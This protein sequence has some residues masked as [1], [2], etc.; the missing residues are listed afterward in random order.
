[1]IR[2]QADVE[3]HLL[4]DC[5]GLR[6]GVVGLG[7]TIWIW[8]AKAAVAVGLWM[9]CLEYVV[10]LLRALA[11]LTGRLSIETKMAEVKSHV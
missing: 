1:V 4:P 7:L 10:E 11:Q 8:P 5:G 2:H 6:D 3:V 9:L